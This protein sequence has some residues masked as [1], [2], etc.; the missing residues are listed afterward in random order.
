[1]GRAAPPRPRHS[2]VKRHLGSRK[3]SE[4]GGGAGGGGES[5]YVYIEPGRGRREQ[6]SLTASL[7]RDQG[8]FLSSFCSHITNVQIIQIQKTRILEGLF[9]FYSFN[10]AM[11]LL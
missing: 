5:F 6:T 7:I 2:P 11:N 10:M 3:I 1:M 9:I 4:R 8:A